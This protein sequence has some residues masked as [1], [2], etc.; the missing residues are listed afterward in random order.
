MFL[1]DASY[2]NMVYGRDIGEAAK[3]DEGMLNMKV[4][5]ENMAWLLKKNPR[6]TPHRP[7]K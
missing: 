3:D 5:G 2:W 6:L 4:L 1:V 7:P